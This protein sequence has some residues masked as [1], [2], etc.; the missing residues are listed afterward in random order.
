MNNKKHPPTPEDSPAQKPAKAAHP[1]PR[2]DGFPQVSEKTNLPDHMP[3]QLVHVSALLSLGVSRLFLSRFDLGIREWRVIAIL[4]HYGPSS[5]SDLVGR[6]AFDK[7]TV[8][9]AIK[10]LERNGMVG[11]CA[12]PTDAR[13]Q[14]IYLTEKGVDLHDRVAPVSIMRKRIVE[15]ALSEK[16]RE[17]LRVILEKL[18][19]QLEWLNQEE[20][21]DNR[22]TDD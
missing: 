5:A 3:Y 15:S 9:R 22:E 18:R 4:G 13:R 7:A 17:S 10:Q 14:L 2:K 21:L 8:S 1:V 12:H 20:A 19:G 16:E 6:A 11:R